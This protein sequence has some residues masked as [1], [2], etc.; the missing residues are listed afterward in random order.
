MPT[1][2]VGF[3][4]IDSEEAFFF[5]LV[6]NWEMEDLSPSSPIAAPSAS[7][8]WYLGVYKAGSRTKER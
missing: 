2:T 3:N 5:F 1:A 7:T 6:G 8:S 4:I